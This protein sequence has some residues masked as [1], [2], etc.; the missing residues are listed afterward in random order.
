MDRAGA[1]VGAVELRAL[2]DALTGDVG[3]FARAE[4]RAALKHPWCWPNDPQ[5]AARARGYVGV[6]PA[7][8]RAGV[9]ALLAVAAG[10]T[11]LYSFGPGRTD[12]QSVPLHGTAAEVLRR[13]ERFAARDLPVFPN[14]R[15]LARDETWRADVVARVGDGVDSRLEGHSFG[16]SMALAVASRLLEIPVRPGLVA[17]ATLELDGSLGA[18]TGLRQKL[19]LVHAIGLGTTRILVHKSQEDEAKKAGDELGMLLEVFGVDALRDA[20]AVAFPDLEAKLT[21]KWS[22]LGAAR[23]AA[24]EI[25]RVTVE[26]SSRVLGARS[27]AAAAG[28]VARSLAADPSEPSRVARWE[29]EVAEAIAQRHEGNA[30]LIEASDEQFQRYPEAVRTRLWAHV[31]QSCADASDEAVHDVLPRAVPRLPEPRLRHADDLKL[32]GAIGRAYAAVGRYKDARLLLEEVCEGWRALHAEHESSFAVSELARVL[33]LVG[34]AAAV[35]ALRGGHYRDLVDD[36]ATS[37]LSIAFAQ[38]AL[39]RAFVQ[40]DRAQAARELLE[41]NE[42]DWAMTPLHLSRSRSRWLARAYHRL[43]LDNDARRVRSELDAH[44]DEASLLARLDAALA[45]GESGD[46]EL[47]QLR[48]LKDGDVERVVARAQRL[49]R[50]VPAAVAEE[51]RY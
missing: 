32:A 38:V 29:A 43:G 23:I 9:V 24:H 26:G 27:L 31:V 50:S 42:R 18:V 35:E 44:E 10:R 30:R 49:G 21:E 16:L 48:R 2:R 51:Y 13:A 25:F 19:E 33:G 14:A 22:D 36:P 34:D 6:E 20:Y 7:P 39:A 47:A 17:T 46:A 4:V 3:A 15:R 8:A 37:T 12:E 1:V 11:T 41:D 40:Q 5:L 28:A 45:R